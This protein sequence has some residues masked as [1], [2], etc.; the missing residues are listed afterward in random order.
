M[1][2]TDGYNSFGIKGYTLVFDFPIYKNIHPT[3]KKITK[4]IIKL[5]GKIYLCK[6]SVINSKDFKNMQT[7]FN[8]IRFKK[9]RKIKKKYFESEQSNRLNI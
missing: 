7:G 3:L 6:D 2:K 8:D 9:I 4:T 5:N 1:G